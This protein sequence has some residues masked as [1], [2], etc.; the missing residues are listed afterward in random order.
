M[1][2]V[3]TI[4]CPHCTAENS[5]MMFRGEYPI[6]KDANV[7]P[8]QFDLVF[9]CP[10]CQHL[11]IVTVTTE[12][13]QSKFSQNKQGDLTTHMA[14]TEGRFPRIS[15]VYPTK[16]TSEAPKHIPPAAERCYLQ[17]ED[18]FRRGYADSAGAMYRKTLDVATKQ[19]DP[20][21]ANK[22]L[23]SRIDALHTAGLLTDSLKDWA[24][25]VRLDGNN[26]S[27]ED[28]ELCDEDLDQLAAFT[29][30]FLIYAFTLPKQVALKRGIDDSVAKD[31]E[32]KV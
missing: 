13:G 4:D 21:L 12:T 2:L 9:S 29:K 1:S 17:A 8:K 28:D 11:S 30:F 20:G 31:N 6:S 25:N 19:L 15:K 5:P 32:P 16:A 7:H 10:K 24:H 26:A 14:R 3:Y 22:K 23:Q 27:H 18:N